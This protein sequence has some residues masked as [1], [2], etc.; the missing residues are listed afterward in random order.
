[1]A[2]G[3]L[4]D[5]NLPRKELF[6][7]TDSRTPV[8]QLGTLSDD[9]LRRDFTVNAMAEDS[10]GGI[11][12]ICCGQEHLRQRMLETP[13]DPHVSFTED[14]LRLLRAFRFM[15][16]KGFRPSARVEAALRNKALW[17]RLS[18]V[19]RERIL[20]ELKKCFQYDTVATMKTLLDFCDEET[21][22]WIFADTLWLKPTMEK[23]R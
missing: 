2:T 8:C 6:Y 18:L 15:I 11:I 9:L 17:S 10:S 7:T 1:M 3:E 23:R 5:F 13:L 21:L 4:A 19:S 20:E 14:P 22:T 12:D 16:T